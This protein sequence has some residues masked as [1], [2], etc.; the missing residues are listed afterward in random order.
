MTFAPFFNSNDASQKGPCDP[1]CLLSSDC[2]TACLCK[3]IRPFCSR[4]FRLL[5]G[6]RRSEEGFVMALLLS[7]SLF[8]QRWVSSASCDGEM[9]VSCEEMQRSSG[10]IGRR[11]ITLERVLTRGTVDYRADAI[12]SLRTVLIPSFKDRQELSQLS[13]PRR[14]PR[15][16]L[17]SQLARP[18]FIGFHQ[19]AN[20][21][22][23]DASVQWSPR[24]ETGVMVY[25]CRAD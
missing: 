16:D 24:C 15:C 4:L 13:K 1:L 8:A 21:Q 23:R 3:S 2:S 25:P 10:S 12:A 6:R 17:F 9:L 7:L 5:R 14:R 22:S 20:L 18:S 19:G 11:S